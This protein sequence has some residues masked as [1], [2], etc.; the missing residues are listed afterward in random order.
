MSP[1]I[2]TP[3]TPLSR[4]HSSVLRNVASPPNTNAPFE[5]AIERWMS[6]TMPSTRF[7]VPPESSPGAARRTRAEPIEAAIPPINHL[8]EMFILQ[9]QQ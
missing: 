8:R 7:G 5:R 2:T 9:H 6:V 1:Q 4:N 3:S